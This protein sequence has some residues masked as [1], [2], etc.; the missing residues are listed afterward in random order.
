MT[1][2]QPEPEPEPDREMC[3]PGPWWAEQDHVLRSRDERGAREVREDITTQRGLRIGVEIIEC[4][5]LRETSGCDE[6]LRA[7]R[8]PV[9]DLPFE[10]C[11][12]VL[13]WDQPSLRAVTA[14]ETQVRPIVGVFNAR[15]R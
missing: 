8:F 4:F 3:F 9:G 6:Q 1:G 12:E 7:V 10:N 13:S 11:S 15:A 2:L 5:D 14:R